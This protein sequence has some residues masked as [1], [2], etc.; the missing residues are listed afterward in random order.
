MSHLP[1]V[2]EPHEIRASNADRE[3]VAKIL[4]DAMAEGRLT[5]GELEERLDQVY[6]AKTIG[7][8]QPLT[9]DLPV[10][11]T[12]VAPR[13]VA[14]PDDRVGGRGTSSAAVAV[15]S[16]AERKGRWTVPP[17]FNA[18]ALMG[19]VDIDLTE[20]RFED[21]ETT[22]QAFALMG[23]IDI[24]VPDDITVHV[25]GIGFMGAFEDHARIEGPP[26]AP[27]VKVTGFAMMGGVDVKRP[28]RKKKDK[29]LEPA[30]DRPQLES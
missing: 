22:I 25:T 30:P 10:Q 19:G 11:G 26:G 28:K 14:A 8:L 9:R 2:P 27:V 4:H 16:G 17:T 24:I 18:F 23:G 13:A 1:A 29:N 15:M 5:V 12:P 20:A 6:A 3:R 21:R 7:E